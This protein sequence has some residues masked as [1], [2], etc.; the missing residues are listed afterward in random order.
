MRINADF[1]CR[2]AL[3]PAN[4]QWVQSP[5]SGVERVM[6]DRVGEEKARATSL[7]RYAPNSYFPHHMHPGGEEILVLSG[8]FSADD[9]HY[10]AGWYLRNP[11]N[12]GHKPYS[13][14]G[15]V[16]FV[17]LRQMTSDESNHVAIDTQDR[18]NW[19]RQSNRDVCP[20]FSNGTEQVSLLRIDAGE[21]LFTDL[22]S[23]GAEL[24]VLAG[25]LLDE[26]QVYQRDGWIRIPADTYAQTKAGPKGATIYLKMG[27]L[28]QVVG[29]EI[30]N[31]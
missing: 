18:T 13:D 30:D 8:T 21:L 3:T 22:V 19:Q 23:G 5:Q 29:S 4:H 15:A 17:K 6:L 2:A 25:E 10:P 26:G 20:L 14:E 16:I 12:S 1:S 11:P 31:T 28:S 7:V 9:T 27:H 24:L